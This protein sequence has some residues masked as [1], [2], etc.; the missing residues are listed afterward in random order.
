MDS[1]QFIKD[2]GTPEDIADAVYFIASDRSKFMT[3][4]TLV[5]DG[6]W[7]AGKTI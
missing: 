2:Y 5:I 4:A 6:G 1:G 7:S 3:G